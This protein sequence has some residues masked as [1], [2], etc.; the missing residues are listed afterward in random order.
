MRARELDWTDSTLVPEASTRRGLVALLFHGIFGHAWDALTTGPF[1]TGFALGLGANNLTIGLLAAITPLAQVF[2][3]PAVYL[4]ER[5]RRRKLMAILFGSGTRAAWTFIA[6][7]PLFATGQ[8]GLGLLLAGMAA[9]ASLG[10]FIGV[11]WNSWIRDFVPQ[12]I[13]GRYFASRLRF[14]VAVAMAVGLAGGYFVSH[15]RRTFPEYQMLAYTFIFGAGVVFAAL[16]LWFLS[17]VPEP[18]YEPPKQRVAFLTFLTQPLRDTGFRALLIFLFLWSFSINL[19]VPFFTVYMLQRLGLSL[20]TVVVFTTLSQISFALFVNAWGKLADRYGNRAVLYV[21]GLSLLFTI[22]AFPFTNLPDRYVLTIP[23]LVAIHVVGG[24]A[25]AGVNLTSSNL[26][27]K[28]SPYGAAS[29]YM[30]ATGLVGAV[31]GSTAPLIAGALADF[32]AAHN[33][34]VRVS[35]TGPAREVAANVVDLR[36]LDFVFLLAFLLGMLALHRLPFV[37]EEG[38]ITEHLDVEHVAGTLTAE[39]K[40]VASIAGLRRMVFWPVTLAGLAKQV[41]SQEGDRTSR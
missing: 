33:F 34:I 3:I 18:T 21:C 2:Q 15:W 31:A 26:A 37:K 29:S 28:A 9:A 35:W 11:A 16:S 5:W 6:L 25:T 14:S 27:L 13:M 40:S 19:A 22:I 39:L 24:L 17:R 12:P 1:L 10:A 8:V 38:D 41:L 4:V 7:I 30:T 20:A 23:L 36:G 32:F